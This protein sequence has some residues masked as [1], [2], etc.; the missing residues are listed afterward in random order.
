M[1]LAMPPMMAAMKLPPPLWLN[2][3]ARITMAIED[4]GSREL[5]G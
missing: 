5:L 1:M 2:H 4:L 3:L